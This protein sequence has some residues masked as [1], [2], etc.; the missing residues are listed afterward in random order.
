MYFRPVFLIF[1]IIVTIALTACLGNINISTAQDAEGSIENHCDT[2]D[3]GPN[4]T[5][6]NT[7][8][9]HVCI[10]HPA[11]CLPLPAVTGNT[12]PVDPSMVHQLQ[13]LINQAP[14]RTFLF[15]AGSY[16]L[17]NIS[18]WIETPGVALRSASG[19]P[20]DVI[21]DSNYL[22]SEII[23]IAASNVTIAELTIRKASTHPIHVV[24]SDSGHTLDTLIYRVNI[25]DPGQQ[26]IKINPHEGK[27]YFPDRGEIACSNIIL[28]D[29]GRKH[30]NNRNAGGIVGHQARDW[31]IRDNRI[32]GFWCDQGLSGHAVHFCRGSR[33]TIV[34]RNYLL[35]NAQGVGF[36]SVDSG[37]VRK[38][39]DKPCPQVDANNYIGH[40]E[41][42]VRNNYIV[43]NSTSL[44][45]SN[46]GFDSGISFSSACNAIA[47]HNSI[48][49]TGS[50]FSG[51]E[52]RYSAS[53]GIKIINNLSSHMLMERDGNP[54]ATLAGNLTATESMF[55][56]V[57][58]SNL[59]LVNTAGA[60]NKGV[61]V[62][63]SICA[64]DIHG[65][66]RG[67]QPDVGADEV[68]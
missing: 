59:N 57:E 30:A 13:S 49:S 34:E 10:Q 58:K 15:A 38:Y 55:Q 26:A 37:E 28:T 67:D 39:E 6:M 19:N 20:E 45:V 64:D 4:A 1:W 24:S 46:S 32:E 12:I 25:I 3:C 52:W 9:S 16:D 27:L 23:T 56:E 31:V 54:S 66:A 14:N 61:P 5:C 11:K 29:Q 63:P 68:G 53:N 21:L 47:V 33:G 18:I 36:G 42:I 43:G 48:F 17:S 7:R 41:G 22:G 60:L 40:Y 51:I 2:I 35:N 62:D 8:E 50:L 44:F 65:E